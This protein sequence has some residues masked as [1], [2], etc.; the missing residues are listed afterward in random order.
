MGESRRHL[1]LEVSS[2]AR[3]CVGSYDNDFTLPLVIERTGDCL[4][5]DRDVGS[6]EAGKLADLIVL[7]ANPL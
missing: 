7:N 6:L 1:T 4:G 5:L 3:A 2:L